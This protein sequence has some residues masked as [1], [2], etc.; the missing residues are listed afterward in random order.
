MAEKQIQLKHKIIL[1]TFLILIGVLL[2]VAMIIA[3]SVRY[4][5]TIRHQIEVTEA[6]IE[7]QY[8]K[9]RLLKKSINELNSIKKN[10]EA[11][12]HITI[13]KGDELRVIRELEQTALSNNVQQDLGV[14]FTEKGPGIKY[15]FYTFTFKNQGDFQN[16]INHLHA[17]EKL[18]YYISIDAIEF[19]KPTNSRGQ[20]V[21]SNEIILNFTGNIFSSQ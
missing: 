1:I 21:D 4:I 12:E 9:V 15:S 19:T 11:F 13:K 6:Q 16:L 17:L 20:T 10:I 14:A 18:P 7:E 3:P 8:Q 2:V 5:K